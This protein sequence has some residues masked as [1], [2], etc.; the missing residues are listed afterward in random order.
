MEICSYKNT[1]FSIKSI[2]LRLIPFTH[3]ALNGFLNFT[4]NKLNDSANLFCMEWVTNQREFSFSSD[5][6]SFLTFTSGPPAAIIFFITAVAVSLDCNSSCLNMACRLGR[7]SVEPS[8]VYR[9]LSCLLPFTHHSYP[10]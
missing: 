7:F 6:N 1:H 10:L 9:F 2:P 5:T 4:N 3:H 8:L